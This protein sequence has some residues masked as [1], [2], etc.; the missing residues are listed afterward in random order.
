[1]KLSACGQ[2]LGGDMLF[3]RRLGFSGTPS[4]LLPREFGGCKFADG[5]DARIL[6]AAN[7][8]LNPT[9]FAKYKQEYMGRLAAK[10]RLQRVKDAL[11]A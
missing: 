10:D 7:K 4:N 5:D 6:E 1:M 2:E 11:S 3:P 9:K 8:A